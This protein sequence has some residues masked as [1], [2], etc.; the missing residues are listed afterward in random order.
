MK[1]AFALSFLICLLLFC[2]L[3]KEAS[4]DYIFLSEYAQTLFNSNSGM[5]ANEANDVL[6]TKDGYIWIATYSGLIRYDGVS[7]HRFG[8][9][10]DDGYAAKSATA[11]YEDANGRLWVCTNDGGL[12]LRENNRFK[13]INDATGGSF[14]TVR[15]ITQDKKG[16]IYIGSSNGV[17]VV[18]SRGIERVPLGRFDN[19]FILRL[20][21][22]DDNRIWGVSR[23][24]DV[25]IVKG[26]RLVSTLDSSALKGYSALSLLRH[27]SGRILAGLG[28]G[29]V[30]S[31]SSDPSGAPHASYLIPTPGM[32][33][34]NGLYEDSHGR[35]WVCSDNGLGFID[36]DLKFRRIDGALLDSSLEQIIEDYEGQYWITSSRQG[37]LQIARNKFMDVNFAGQIPRGVVNAALPLGDRLLIG[38]DDGLYALDRDFKRIDA[39]Y[40]KELA[41]KRIR[42]IMR[43]SKGDVWVSTYSGD[44][45]LRL[46]K[47]GSQKFFTKGD[48]LPDNKVRMAYECSNGDIAVATNGGAAVVRDGR[49]AHVYDGR[50]GLTSL[51]ILCLE[52]GADGTLY[53]GS[54]GGG[55]YAVRDG[56]MIKN[57]TKRDGLN[58]DVILRMMYDKKRRG[59]WVSAGNGLSW[60]SDGGRPRALKITAPVTSGIFDIK[61]GPRGELLLLAD[62][63]LHLCDKDQL[64][65]GGETK[66]TSYTRRDGLLSTVTANSWNLYDGRGNLFICTANGLYSINLRDVR[67][68]TVKPKLAVNRVVVDGKI[69]ENP[70]RLEIPSTTQRLTLDLAVLS[71]VN[72]SYNSGEYF[73]K[74]FDM[75][76]NSVDAKGLAN[77][78]YTNLRGGTYTLIFRAF[79][80][81]GVAAGEP[82]EI[83]IEK[84][85]AIYEQPIFLLLVLTSALGLVFACTRWYYR[86]HTRELERRHEELTSITTQALTAIANTIDAKDPYTRGHSSRVAEYSMALAK[87]LGFEDEE[88]N[89]LYYTALLH[90]IGK[91][92]IPDNI[93]NKPGRLT[94]EEYEMMKQHSAKGG[95]ILA[96]ITIISDIKNGAAFHHERYDGKGYNTG[97]KGEEIP[98]IARIIC[99]ADS[100]DAMA[101]T[102]PYRT[103]R[104]VEYIISELE[105]NSGTQFDPKLAQMMIDLIKS[106]ELKLRRNAAEDEAEPGRPEKEA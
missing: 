104:S 48:G 7:F 67:R 88:L 57:Y 86:R 101:T 71:F 93:L 15:A 30:L 34:I 84:A 25:F 82:L 11:L 10:A 58:A 61:E 54:D 27:S 87:K 3:P 73:L 55:I 35:V 105:K 78:S 92:G 37:L 81:D 36:G 41:G 56:K 97:L 47:D 79:N 13:P 46:R 90:D 8:G 102:R 59:L 103:A 100:V 91:I 44:G 26:R 76:M 18:T 32:K 50:G 6:Q 14:N 2:I 106:G 52:E 96:D 12:Y 80:S 69:Y 85:R 70:R 66:W 68:N 28:E 22:D 65:N 43:D 72:S 21:C 83:V 38:A 74:G 1:K 51:T 99:V 16:D 62:T 9:T 23:T 4:A 77:I 60:I 17:G 98:L 63:G 24:G 42:N 53:L 75:G 39:P 45:L 19:A 49:V 94:D 31:I 33:S 20:I 5:G 64:L 95:D 29:G 40:V 89:N